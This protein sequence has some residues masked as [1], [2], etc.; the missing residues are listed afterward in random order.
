MQTIRKRGIS[1]PTCLLEDQQP[2]HYIVCMVDGKHRSMEINVN[3]TLRDVARS[4]WNDFLVMVAI[5]R[6]RS[7]DRSLPARSATAGR[8]GKGCRMISRP[9]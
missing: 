6:I 9:R 2:R 8:K 4:R 3:N 1:I 5:L 7:N